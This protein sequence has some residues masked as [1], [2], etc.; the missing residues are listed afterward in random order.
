[1]KTFNFSRSRL[2]S[3]FITYS[4]FC[5][6]DVIWDDIFSSFIPRTKQCAKD[7]M[8]IGYFRLFCIVIYSFI[9][10]SSN[11]HMAS[12]RS[13]N[14]YKNV[15]FFSLALLTISASLILLIC[16]ISSLH[17]LSYELLLTFTFTFSFLL[18]YK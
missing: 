14:I 3:P 16:L 17:I 11:G 7:K 4:E 15:F 9:T 2:T 10:S 5:C 8:F 12:L 6:A 1:M 13:S 18:C